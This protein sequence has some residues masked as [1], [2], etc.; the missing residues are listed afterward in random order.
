M[1]LRVEIS[2]VPT[3]LVLVEENEA[4]DPAVWKSEAAQ[5]FVRF[6]NSPGRDQTH[7]SN[8]LAGTVADVVT[9]INRST[10]KFPIRGLKDKY[11]DLVWEWLTS[12]GIRRGTVVPAEFCT[13]PGKSLLHEAG[14][15]QSLLEMQQGEEN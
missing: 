7:I 8:R 6:H 14:G 2:F 1:Q 11:M 13:P 3:H 15:G 9:Q 5:S 10:W 12:L 4:P